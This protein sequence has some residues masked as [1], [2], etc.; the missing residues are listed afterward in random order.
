MNMLKKGAVTKFHLIMMFLMMFGTIGGTV[1][2]I[3]GAF[4]SETSTAVLSNITNIVL[5]AVILSM[6]IMG[7]V[8]IIKDYSKPA[9]VFYKAFMFLHVGVC[10]LSIIINLCFYTV[11]PLMITIC[12]LYAFKAIDLMILVFWKDLGKKKTWILFYVIL[13]LDIAALILAVIN[14]VNI[15]FDF[16]FTGYV[17]ALIADGTIGLSVKG[18]YEN[19]EARGSK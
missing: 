2:F 15:G 16:S 3:I 13:G 5:M 10:V 8:Y 11:N 7:A 17:T 12:I 9:A 1:N 19:K 18:K 6:L 4:N 14:M